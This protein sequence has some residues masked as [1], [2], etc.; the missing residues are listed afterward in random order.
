MKINVLRSIFIA[1]FILL[2][3]AGCS[4]LKDQWPDQVPKRSLFLKA[5][6]LDQ[7]NKRI[8]SQ[9]EYLLWIQRFYLGWE[10]YRNGWLKV[11][12]QLVEETHNPDDR[13]IVEKKMQQIGLKISRE[14]AKKHKQRKIFTRHVSIWG[15]ALLESLDRNEPLL[16][17]EK[18]NAD[19][20]ALLAHK[21]QPKA[22]T[23]SRYYPQDENNPFL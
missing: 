2:L 10:I 16:L 3:T 5:Y 1:S 13:K 4:H 18:V 8:Q 17:I 11:T 19:V 12:N 23:A 22:I 15:N 14:W 6:Q 21:L 20:D 7:E 9:E